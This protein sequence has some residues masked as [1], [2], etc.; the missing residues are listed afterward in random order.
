MDEVPCLARRWSQS[1]YAP[2]GQTPSIS[3][4]RKSPQDLT[5]IPGAGMPLLV[6]STQ[7]SVP[8]VVVELHVVV[9]AHAFR[10]RVRISRRALQGS[11]RRRE[12]ASRVG[13]PEP[14]VQVV[15][16]ELLGHDRIVPIHW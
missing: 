4:P 13:L 16:A 3:D 14:D 10:V 5:R 12:H 8:G 9:R 1:R 7:Y 6:L 2:R 15:V 11:V